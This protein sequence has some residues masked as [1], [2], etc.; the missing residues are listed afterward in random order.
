MRINNRELSWL[1]FNERVLQEAQDKSVPLMQRLRF[2]G[3]FSNNQDEFIK[4]RV[5]KLIQLNKSKHKVSSD[6][7][8]TEE[9]LELVNSKIDSARE[10]FDKTYNEILSEM[11]SNNIF[12]VNETQ[13]SEHQIAFC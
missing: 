12:V 7:F 13:L 4:V 9:L 10:T 1:A 2:L 11:E 3:I 6:G 5:A 8:S